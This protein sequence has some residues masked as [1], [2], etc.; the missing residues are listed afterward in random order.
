MKKVILSLFSLFTVMYCI[1]ACHPNTIIISENRIQDGIYDSEY[2]AYPVSELLEDVMSSVKMISG[3]TNYR[4]Y[5]FDESQ[6]I[7]IQNLQSAMESI[8]E[9]MTSIIEKPNYGAGTVI[10]NN[11]KRMALLTCAHVVSEPDTQVYYYHNSEKGKVGYIQTI[12]CKIEQ[13]YTVVGHSY[14]DELEIVAM[15][16]DK[17]L[18]LVSGKVRRDA[19]QADFP[20]INAVLGDASAIRWGSQAFI[21][22]FPNG[23]KMVNQGIVSL[24]DRDAGES[25]LINK[26]MSRGISGAIVL[27]IMDGSAAFE[28][29][30]I[31]KAVPIRQQVVLIP[32]QIQNINHLDFGRPYKEDI[33]VG[34]HSSDVPGISIAIGIDAIKTFLKSSRN[35]Q[36]ANGLFI[37]SFKDK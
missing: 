16:H 30:G 26:S 32:D 35:Q 37:D 18:A 33:Y 25:F 15:D 23:K 22:G 1:F 27:A 8:D 4:V 7:T 28:I 12:H 21:I 19:S 36:K 2:P 13:R 29:I 5:K 20:K 24:V 11:G 14:L 34:A 9:N 3:L 6:K 17:D 10:Y 31:I